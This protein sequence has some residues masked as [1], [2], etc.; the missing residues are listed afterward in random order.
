MG[1]HIGSDVGVNTY[2]LRTTSAM[3]VATAQVEKTGNYYELATTQDHHLIDQGGIEMRQQQVGEKY[4]SAEVIKEATLADLKSDPEIF[5]KKEDGSV[6]LQLYQPPMQFNDPHAWGM[7]IDLSKCIGCHACVAACQAENN[8]PIVGKDQVLHNRQ[9]HWIRID[10]YFKGD[11]DDP[12]PEVVF[13][14][15]T[16][17]HC[18]NAPC[19]QVCPV[20]AT[21]HDSE[22]LNV[23]VYNRCVG[24]RYCSNNCPYKVRRFNYL[25]WQSQ[26]PR[27]D[28]YPKPWL[29][30]PDQQQLDTIPKVKQ[31]MFNPEVTVR[32]RGVMEK[33][34]F[35]VQRIHTTTISQRARNEKLKDG[36]IMTACQQSCPTQ[37]I[38]FGDL[39]DRKSKVSKWHRDP[40]AYGLLDEALQTKPRNRF[41]AK[42]SNPVET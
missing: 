27:H 13:Q 17:Q 15:L 30:I 7:G 34:T 12:N 10:R 28:K 32:M 9:M 35:C 36:D 14:P 21:V 8:I 11:A 42:L 6:S 19:E 26:D 16:C 38:V 1:E 24:T 41:L 25:D 23:M 18:E 20:G 31:M 33:C 29:N 2:P 40:R 4:K 3:F 39:N 22:G 37:A 5:A